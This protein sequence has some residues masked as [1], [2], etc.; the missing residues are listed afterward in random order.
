MRFP[1]RPVSRRTSHPCLW[2][3]VRDFLAGTNREIRH[4]LGSNNWVVS[5][6]HTATG[7]PLLANDTH[8]E[9]TVPSIW[10]EVHLTA[11]DWNVEG[12]TLPGAPLVVIGHNDQIAWGFTNNGA[13]VQD[14]Y[15]ETFNPAAPD[16]YRV[17][18]AWVKSAGVR[19]SYPRK[20]PGRRAS[21]S[22][23]PRATDR[24]CGATV[25][26]DTRCAGRP[27]NLA[28]CRTLTTGWA[29]R[30]NWEEFRNAMKQVWGPAQNTVYAD[31]RREISDTSW[32]RA[33]RFAKRATAKFP[34]PAIPMT[35]NGPDTF[36]STSCRRLSIPRA[37]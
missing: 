36:R 16:E 17:N 3:Q 18:G 37:D 27:P 12:F 4:G 5:G 26:K 35:M 9:L 32:P 11:P 30:S 29:K 24:W 21:A 34:F 10:Y 14:L 6:A 2:P 19:R 13:D 1:C 28:A 25:I 15:I 31:M 8:L 22:W 33:F 20:R 23:S 7:K